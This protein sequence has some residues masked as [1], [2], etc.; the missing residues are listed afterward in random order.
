M[1]PIFAF[2]ALR[3]LGNNKRTQRQVGRTG[4]DVYRSNLRRLELSVFRYLT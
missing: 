2:H 1:N 3:E 4:A